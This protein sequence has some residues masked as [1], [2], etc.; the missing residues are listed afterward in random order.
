M[1]FF[2]GGVESSIHTSANEQYW[3]HPA[4]GEFCSVSCS[5]VCVCVFQRVQD[6]WR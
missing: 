4:G 3:S 6:E 2:R 5:Q 1:V